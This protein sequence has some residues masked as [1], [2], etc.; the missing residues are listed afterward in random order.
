MGRLFWKFFLTFWLALLVAGASVGTTVWLRHNAWQDGEA[1]NHSVDLRHAS[2]FVAVAEN[3]IQ[4]GGVVA[5][6]SFLEEM[7]EPHFPQC[8]RL[9]IKIGTFFS[10][11]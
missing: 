9:T 4:H 10:A 8:M 3:I 1:V 11:T 2:S 7:D 6:R 5:L